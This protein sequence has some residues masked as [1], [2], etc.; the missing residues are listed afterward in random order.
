MT[1]PVYVDPV[2]GRLFYH[3]YTLL[4]Y[5]NFSQLL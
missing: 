4:V 2:S 3:T 5:L 1:L